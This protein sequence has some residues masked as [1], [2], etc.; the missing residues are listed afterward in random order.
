MSQVG[1]PFFWA[2]WRQMKL[3]NLAQFCSVRFH[4]RRL[5]PMI[6]DI[7]LYFELSKR[8]YGYYFL[9]LGW[10]AECVYVLDR[11]GGLGSQR[12]LTA[13][14]NFSYPDSCQAALS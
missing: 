6:R 14:L 1:H 4:I 8:C 12:S 2:A 7:V 11:D 5:S 3:K 9:G 10:L 13:A